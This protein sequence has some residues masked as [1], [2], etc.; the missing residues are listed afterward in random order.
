MVALTPAF[1]LSALSMVAFAAGPFDGSHRAR[2]HHQLARNV[3]PRSSFSLVAKYQGEDFTDESKWHY[4]KDK[5]PTNGNVEYVSQAVAVSN[6]LVSVQSDNSTKI[7]VETGD[8]AS[9]VNRKSVRISS[10]EKWSSGLLIADFA[11]MPTGCGTWPAF[12]AVGDNWPNGGEIDIIE[13]VNL[14]DSNQLT[15]HAG[16]GSNC[17]TDTNPGLVNGVA[18]FLANIGNLECL[19][20]PESNTGCTF[21]D[22]DPNSFGTGF[23]DVGGRVMAV[24]RDTRGIF[25][26]SF[27]R[28]DV[29]KDITAGTP[30]PNNWSSP[31]AYWSSNTCDFDEH[32]GAQTI[33]LNTDVLGDWAKSDLATSN[34]PVTDP[35]ALVA[36]GSHWENAFWK[37]N[38]IAMY[39]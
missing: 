37:V 18:P 32:F 12:W 11:A 29:P 26:W 34:C 28:A 31:R 6:K 36:T 5:D 39:D 19:S 20:S 35:T 33:V 8:L 1:V 13:G 3:V 14:K 30:N 38:Y 25:M 23:N 4:F 21:F 24:L 9:G 2:S 7:A 10:V 17:T 22:N 15:L 27:S 16:S